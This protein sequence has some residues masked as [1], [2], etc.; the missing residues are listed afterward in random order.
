MTL[1]NAEY[2]RSVRPAERMD[3]AQ[4]CSLTTMIGFPWR[5]HKLDCF[6]LFLAAHYMF[7][8]PAAERAWLGRP[9]GVTDVCLVDVQCLVWLCNCL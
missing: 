6:R 3:L 4:V 1:L 5:D 8:F 9:S 7:F 2:V